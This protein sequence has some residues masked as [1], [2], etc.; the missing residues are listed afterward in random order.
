MALTTAIMVVPWWRCCCSGGCDGC[1]D[2]DCDRGGGDDLADTD[3]NGARDQNYGG[4]AD[5]GV[6]ESGDGDGEDGD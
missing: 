4:V 5:D 3:G 2:G 1:D 6:D